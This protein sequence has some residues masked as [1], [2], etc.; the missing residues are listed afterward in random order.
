MKQIMFNN[1]DIIIQKNQTIYFIF[2]NFQVS[3]SSYYKKCHHIWK[4]IV[5]PNSHIKGRKEEHV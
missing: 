3:I 5:E 1:I 2:L 4:S